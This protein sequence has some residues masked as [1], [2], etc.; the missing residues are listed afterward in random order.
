MKTAIFRAI[1]GDDIERVS[2]EISAYVYNHKDAT[3]FQLLRVF[4][5]K[6]RQF[7]KYIPYMIKN[8]R[9]EVQCCQ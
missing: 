3:N 9:A 4:L 6:Y 5:R 8:A 7:K 1:I 2:A